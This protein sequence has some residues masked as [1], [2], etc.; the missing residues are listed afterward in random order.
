MT[1][2]KNQI[3]ALEDRLAMVTEVYQLAG[4]IALLLEEDVVTPVEIE[5]LMKPVEVFL[6]EKFDQRG[7]LQDVRWL[8]KFKTRLRKEG[9]A[10]LDKEFID[11]YVGSFNKKAAWALRESNISLIQ[12]VRW[13]PEILQA[14]HPDFTPF[15]V[16]RI[17]SSLATMGLSFEMDEKDVRKIFGK[18]AKRQTQPIQ[19]S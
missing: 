1:S 15:R 2:K 6:E 9:L 19:Q 16:R 3:A 18:W 7:N 12:L 13:S 10:A 8:E 4:K 17:G 11:H 5:A 14:R